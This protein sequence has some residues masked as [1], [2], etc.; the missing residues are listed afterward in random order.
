MSIVLERNIITP[1]I[2]MQE[3]DYVMAA[4]N[5]LPLTNSWLYIELLQFGVH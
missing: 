2:E 5:K 3:K 1:I 4:F